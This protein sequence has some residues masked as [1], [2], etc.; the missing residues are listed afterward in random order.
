[1]ITTQNNLDQIAG[2]IER[3][4]HLRHPNWLATGLTPGVWGAAAIRLLEV[5][6]ARSSLP[7]DPELFVAVQD[8]KT[9]RRDPWRELTQEGATKAY[10]VAVRRIV[11]QLRRE[12]G[13]ELRWAAR[14]LNSGRSIEELTESPKSKVSPMIKVMLCHEYDR[15]DLAEL[16]RPAAEAQHLACPLYRAA[17][18][19]LVPSEV[20]PRSRREQSF[21]ANISAQVNSYNWN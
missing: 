4:Y 13:A 16:I 3:A 14:Y 11:R 15:S 6:D 18:K 17:C 1:M 9:F 8:Y 19:H 5:A 7:V 20:Y 21:Q 10:R 12:L 2:R